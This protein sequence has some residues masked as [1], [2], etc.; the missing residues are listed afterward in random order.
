MG[1]VYR[2]NIFKVNVY[3]IYLLFIIS[4]YSFRC[5]SLMK[6][7]QNRMTTYTNVSVFM[8]PLKQFFIEKIINNANTMAFKSYEILYTDSDYRIYIIGRFCKHFCVKIILIFSYNKVTLFSLI[9]CA[10]FYNIL[11][12]LMLF[13]NIFF[14]LQ[15]FNFEEKIFTINMFLFFVYVYSISRISWILNTVGFIW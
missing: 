11:I 7:L 9:H 8:Y 13:Y 6:P 5:A 10:V 12:I 1:I 15:V 3:F 14:R 4:E 2:L